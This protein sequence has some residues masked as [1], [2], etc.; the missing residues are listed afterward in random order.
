MVQERLW[1]NIFPDRLNCGSVG[2]LTMK[3]RYVLYRVNQS[4][5]V[6]IAALSCLVTAGIGV[7]GK[8]GAE[9]M[10]VVDCGMWAWVFYGPTDN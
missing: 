5:M 9:G 4:T 8:C 6:D 1:G 10:V 3:R 2:C 7:R